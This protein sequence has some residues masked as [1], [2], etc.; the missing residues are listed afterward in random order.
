MDFSGSSRPVGLASG[1]T[2]R[3]GEMCQVGRHLR[4]YFFVP[5]STDTSQLKSAQGGGRKRKKEG[6][7]KNLLQISSGLRMRGTLEIK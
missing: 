4:E 7:E 3:S 1:H 6:E 2:L 5:F